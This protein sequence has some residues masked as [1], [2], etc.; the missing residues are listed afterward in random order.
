MSVN[1]LRI[2]NYWI[3]QH[4][5][6]RTTKVSRSRLRRRYE[7][8]KFSCPTWM[9]STG[10]STA[11]ATTLMFRYYTPTDVDIN[12]SSL[13]MKIM[14]HC[15][16]LQHA[17]GYTCHILQFHVSR[18]NMGHLWGWYFR[19]N[20]TPNGYSSVSLLPPNP[21]TPRTRVSTFW[22]HFTTL[23]DNQPLQ[24]LVDVRNRERWLVLGRFEDNHR[25]IKRSN[26]QLKSKSRRN[27]R[28][29]RSHYWLYQFSHASGSILYIP[30]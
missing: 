4:P 13:S 23:S 16:C 3:P 19:Y 27:L 29:G 7:D 28:H 18:K 17:W 1:V 2:A 30:N 21:N 6:P 14:A 25:H 12:Q 5:Q 24:L 22:S 10:T 11:T 26:S 9:T 8:T 15:H 20:A